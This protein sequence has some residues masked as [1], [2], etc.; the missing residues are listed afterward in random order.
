MSNKYNFIQL[1]LIAEIRG[2]SNQASK[3]QR[4]QATK[5]HCDSL[6]LDHLARQVVPDINASVAK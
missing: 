3:I 2:P 5:E 4:V 6:S 1:L